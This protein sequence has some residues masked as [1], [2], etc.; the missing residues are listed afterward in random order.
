VDPAAIARFARHI[1]L[2]EIGLEGQQRLAAARVLIAGDD[3]AAEVAARYLAASGVGVVRTVGGAG[4]PWPVN[5]LAWLAVLE[6]ERPDLVLRSGFDDDALLGAVKRVG[7]P[8]IVVRGREDLVDVLS[9]PSTPAD[10]EASLDVP[11]RRAEPQRAGAAAVVAGTLAAAE[12]LQVLVG[13]APRPSARH[14]RVPLDGRPPQV[15]EIPWG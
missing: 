11:L 1:S 15:Q 3:L 14:M 13:R 12:A 8:A 5:G 9:F 2:P 10:P 6:D 7:V 4:I